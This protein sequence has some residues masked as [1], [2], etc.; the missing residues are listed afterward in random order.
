VIVSGL[1][2]SAALKTRRLVATTSELP[3]AL[4]VGSLVK[5]MPPVPGGAEDS[6]GEAGEKL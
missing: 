4:L 6:E 3:T 5:V 1:E 2:P